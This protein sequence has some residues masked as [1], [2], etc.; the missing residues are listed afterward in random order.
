MVFCQVRFRQGIMLVVKIIAEAL[1][2]LFNIGMA[3]YQAYRFDV[4]QKTINH[5][6]RLI[7]YSL[8]ISLILVSAIW[9]GWSMVWLW[10]AS[11]IVHFPLFSSTLN[12]FRIPKRRWNYHNTSDVGGSK[13]DQW[14]GKYYTLAW[15]ISAVTWG[16]LQYLIFKQAK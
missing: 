5:T 16:A 12:F 2:I 9:L 11:M 4:L 8:V 14:L 15:I 6:A 10:T 7:G 13:L 3:H 1:V